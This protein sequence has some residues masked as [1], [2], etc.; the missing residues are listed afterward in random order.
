MD[1]TELLAAVSAGIDSASGNA[2]APVVE[3]TPADDAAVIDGAAD[4]EGSAGGEQGAEGNAA[5]GT[6]ASAQSG[7]DPAGSA[8]PV[9]ST[10]KRGPDGKF[11]PAD[12]KPAADP[13]KPADGTATDKAKPAAK[14][15]DPIND[16]ID[17]RL[18]E[19]TRNR[20]TTLVDTA[21]TLT[22][23]VQ[24]VTAERDEILGYIQQTG[25]TPEQYSQTLNYLSLVN[26]PNRADQEKALEVMLQEVNALSR[27]LGKPV[28]GVDLVSEHADL[29]QAVREGDISPQHAQELAA[30]R[31]QAKVA[32]VREGAAQQNTAAQQE[33]QA[34]R[35]AL[36]AL[37]NQ[38]AAD[39]HFAYKRGILVET[40]KPVFASI[41]PSKWASTF[42]AAYDKLPA[43][44]AAAPA[45][46]PAVKLPTNTPL[47]PNNPAGGQLKAPGSALEAM[48]LALGG[49]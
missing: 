17:P 26:S 9:G 2:P 12:G 42:K 39:P 40:L 23:E 30:A 35:D 37:G 38:L 7:N 25:A 4:A 43:P 8:A 31:A 34:G 47:R 15:P 44:V 1:D 19:G 48:N 33:I 5:E 24:K 6:E 3:E 29:V 16:P 21:K 46:K 41:H 36:T 28:P 20:I 13:A 45:P 11:L 18:K 49:Q 10:A 22:A 32:T 27:M 14:A